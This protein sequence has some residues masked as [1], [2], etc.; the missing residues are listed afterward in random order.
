MSHGG[1]VTSPRMTRHISCDHQHGVCVHGKGR[2]VRLALGSYA[3]ARACQG[4]SSS[5]ARI[6]LGRDHLLDEPRAERVSRR[7]RELWP[8][9]QDDPGDPGD[10]ELCQLQGRADPRTG[11]AGSSPKKGCPPLPRPRRHRGPPPQELRHRQGLAVLQNLPAPGQQRDHIRLG[12]HE[13]ALADAFQPTVLGEAQHRVRH[14]RPDPS[15]R[16][17]DRGRC[18]ADPLQRPQLSSTGPPQRAVAE[19]DLLVPVFV[20][21]TN[22]P[23]GPTTTWSMFAYRRPGQAT[24][25]NTTQPDGRAASASAVRSPTSAL[26]SQRS[27]RRAR[28]SDSLRRRATSRADSLRPRHLGRLSAHPT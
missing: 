6:G 17:V 1:S 28:R 16:L 13:D 5:I 14:R 25:C 3:E 7:G 22:T 12:A 27:H 21:I 20:S 26:C 10:E 19:G 8:R 11:L 18:V 4:S 2:A 24:S 15:H 9:E 23:P